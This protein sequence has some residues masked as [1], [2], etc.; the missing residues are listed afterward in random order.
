MNNYRLDKNTTAH[1]NSFEEVAKDFGCKPV[2]KKT[3]NKDK[4]I[5]QQEKFCKRHKCKACGAMMN[6]IPNTNI[7]TCTNPECKGIKITTTDKD[8]NERVNYITSYNVLDDKSS[9]IANNI[10]G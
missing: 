5:S 1:Y 8:G 2:S 9:E 7:M 4:L 3:K 10:F 6:F